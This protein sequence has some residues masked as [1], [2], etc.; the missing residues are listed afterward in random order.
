MIANE[1][2][3]AYEKRIVQRELIRPAAEALKTMGV[4]R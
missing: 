3:P 4:T 1:R 2:G